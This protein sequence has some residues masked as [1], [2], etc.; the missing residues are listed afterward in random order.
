MTRINANVQSL[1]ARRVLNT[2]QNA[3]NK[4]LSRLARGQTNDLSSKDYAVAQ[5][6][7][8]APTEQVSSVRGRLGAFQ[9]GTLATTMNALAVT[10]ENVTA[11]ES[12]IRDADF[13]AET[14]ELTRAQILVNSSM[15]VLQSANQ[16]PASIPQQLG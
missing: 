4:S 6:V 9:K 2:E 7:K 14:S 3:F 8:R 13:A 5:R 12:A 11:A 15:L 10:L 16:Q 1:I